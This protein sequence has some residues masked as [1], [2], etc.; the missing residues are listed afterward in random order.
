MMLVHARNS[1]HYLHDHEAPDG[2]NNGRVEG[3]FHGRGIGT[4][5]TVGHDVSSLSLV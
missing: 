3:V 5:T 2:D 1:I 4:S